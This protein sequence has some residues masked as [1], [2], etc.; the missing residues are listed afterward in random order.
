MDIHRHHSG[1]TNDFKHIH[2][3]RKVNAILWLRKGH[4]YLGYFWWKSWS[5]NVF[6]IHFPTFSCA[7][8]FL[9]Y[10][11]LAESGIWSL[12]ECAIQIEIF[13]NLVI[14]TISSQFYIERCFDFCKGNLFNYLSRSVSFHVKIRQIWLAV[15][16]IVSVCFGG[17]GGVHLGIPRKN[18]EISLRYIPVW[19][20]G[21]AEAVEELIDGR[22][23]WVHVWGGASVRKVARVCW[24][25]PHV[26]VFWFC[27]G[28]FLLAK[29]RVCFLCM[30]YFMSILCGLIMFD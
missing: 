4:E 13:S 16:C 17:G 23:C 26:P 29:I 12:L 27:F 28:T 5:F 25:N 2:L 24:K 8:F 11:Y 18:P 21:D 10:T 6:W 3:Y 22:W 14:W 19:S 1:S 30:V 15:S 9:K 20:S 7:D